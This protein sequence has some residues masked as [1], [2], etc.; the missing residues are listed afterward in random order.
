MRATTISVNIRPKNEVYLIGYVSEERKHPA[1]GVHDDPLAVALL[2]E[3]E[4]Q[5]LL[6]ISIDVIMITAKK[7]SILKKK[8]KEDLDIPYEN[9]VISVIHSHSD[10]D[11]FNA[12]GPLFMSENEEYFNHAIECIVNGIKGIEDTLVDV[13]AEIGTTRIHGYYS[14][15]NDIHKEFDD[16]AS[17]IKF[18]NQDTVVAA[19][20]NF[21]CH[22]TVL[23]INNM[24]VSSDLIGEVRA[25][26][27]NEIG[28]VPYTFTGASGDISNRQYRQGNGF[29]ELQ[30]VGEGITNC[31]TQIQNYEEID[32]QSLSIKETSYI[33]DYDNTLRYDDYKRSLKKAKAVL[34]RN[35]SSAD[36][37]KLRSSEVVILEDKLTINHVHFPVNCKIITMKDLTIVTFPGE[38]ASCFGL[39]LKKACK[40]KYFLCIGYADDYQGYFI[41][42]SEY[43]KCYETIATMTP[44]G[45]SE[46]I[47]E[48]IGDLL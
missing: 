40:S 5:K 47:I 14:N 21:N 29:E 39:A 8:I 18:K 6:F 34:H 46:R 24:L 1:I 22:S 7:A 27:A 36:E 43:G 45:E 19:M 17:L 38:L 48:R 11:G 31:I 35:D 16:H 10:P 28:V 3:I 4:K 33:I 41:E 9:I 42:K 25:R 15:R 26:I 2:L 13:K 20:L 32:L 12:I 44:K 30:R 23:G 37:R